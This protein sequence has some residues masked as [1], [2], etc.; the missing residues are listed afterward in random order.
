MTIMVTGAAGFIGYHCSLNLLKRGETVIGVDNLNPY[1]DV[2]LKKAR[3]A[4]LCSQPTFKFYPSDIADKDAM[5][6]LAVKEPEIRAIIH[7]AAQAGVRYSL[8]HPHAYTEANLTG[9]LNIL[10]MCRH[11][12]NFKHLIYASSSSVYGA[13]TK[14]PF[15]IQDPVNE[16]MSLYAATKRS[17]ELMAYTYSHLFGFAATGLRFFTVYGPWGRPDMSAFIFTKAIIENEEIPVFNRGIMRRNFTYIDDIV[18]G[19]IAALDKPPLLL[20]NSVPHRIYNLGNDRSENL[21]D[22]IATLEKIIGKKARLQLLPMQPGDV[23]ETLA[24]ITET[25]Q[26]LGFIPLTNIDQGLLNFVNWYQDFYKVSSAALQ[27]AI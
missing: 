20:P 22:F 26:D 27:H 8:T 2:S 14:L 6:D 23:K 19:V 11:L 24:D 12:K 3:L 15:S 25:T 17:G 18:K 9:Q 4:Q 13:N 21:M 5:M 10:E 7:L 16:P 1:Y